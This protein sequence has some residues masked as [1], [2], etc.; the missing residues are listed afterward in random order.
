MIISTVPEK[1]TVYV[2]I[3]T[4]CVLA[5]VLLHF[6]YN[7]YFAAHFTTHIFCN[8]HQRTRALLVMPEIAASLEPVNHPV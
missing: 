8:H 6:T 3:G 4:L 1:E 2:C 7:L 5:V